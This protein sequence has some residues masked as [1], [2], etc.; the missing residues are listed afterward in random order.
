MKKWVVSYAAQLMDGDI[1]YGDLDVKSVSIVGAAEAG[2]KKLESRATEIPDLKAVN[3][4]AVEVA[5]FES[6]F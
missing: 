3:I 5:A 1:I 6:L 2:R 4:Y